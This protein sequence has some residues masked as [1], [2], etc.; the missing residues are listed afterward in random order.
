VSV[1][2]AI[3]RS[4]LS[5]FVDF[6]SLLVSKCESDVMLFP[7]ALYNEKEKGKGALYY[8]DAV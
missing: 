6:S 1:V 2:F 8:V 4:L 5:H 7:T 3:D